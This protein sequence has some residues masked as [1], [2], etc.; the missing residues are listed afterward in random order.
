MEK[1]KNKMEIVGYGPD[2][3]ANYELSFNTVK[4]FIFLES[5]QILGAD[6]GYALNKILISG[7]AKD[8]YPFNFDINPA[9]FDPQKLYKIDFN[10]WIKSLKIKRGDPDIQAI[11]KYK[12]KQ[13]EVIERF[14]VNGKKI[15]FVKV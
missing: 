9:N 12:I 6:P 14:E 2:Q 4:T 3:E 13:F 1:L 7:V 15:Q 10:I 11:V 5:I 8:G